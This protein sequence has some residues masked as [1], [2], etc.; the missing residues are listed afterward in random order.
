MKVG[1]PTNYP[2]YGLAV[3]YVVNAP[4]A[5][6]LTVP[7]MPAARNLSVNAFISYYYYCR[8]VS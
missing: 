2:A 3:R 8:S 4:A 7:E 1:T 6:P 5:I